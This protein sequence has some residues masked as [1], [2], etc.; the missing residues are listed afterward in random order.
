MESIIWNDVKQLI[1]TSSPRFVRLGV[2]PQQVPCL[3]GNDGT[4]LTT[5]PHI[6]FGYVVSD[7]DAIN[8][9]ATR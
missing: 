5:N 6:A 3:W 2:T 8:C 4:V 7:W 9:H 1:E